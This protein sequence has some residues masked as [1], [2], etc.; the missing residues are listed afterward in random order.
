MTKNLQVYISALIAQ[1]KLSGNKNS[2]NGNNII[3]SDDYSFNPNIKEL[4][5]FNTAD[6]SKKDSEYYGLPFSE[7]AAMLARK[8][9]SVYERYL[10]S[11]EGEMLLAK[12]NEYEISYD[13]DNLNII[14]L[15]NKVEEFKEAITIVNQYDI[16]WQSFGYDLLTIEQE[17]D[18]IQQVE[19][20][21]VR[22]ARS[23]FLTTKGVV[24]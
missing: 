22:C 23:Q 15:R 1:K 7:I 14:L 2:N 4:P 11:E 16:D 8:A 20:D 5:R 18:D 13:L 10:A 3:I 24:A 12:A 17:I 6:N 9:K 21:Y 19:N